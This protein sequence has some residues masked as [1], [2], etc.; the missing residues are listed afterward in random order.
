MSNKSTGKES[1]IKSPFRGLERWIKVLV[2]LYSIIGIALFY[3]Q[4]YFLFHPTVLPRGH[5]YHF[6]FPFAEMDL[7]FNNTDTV[8]MVKFFPTDSTR[9]G[10]VLYFHG[11]KGNINRYAKF[12]GNFTKHGYE[13]WM[14]DYPGF[15]KSIGQR[16]E[17][18][19]YQQAVQLYKLALTKYHQDSIVI[20][21]KSF[22]TGIASY[23]AAVSDAKQLILETPYYSIPALY[24]CYAPIYPSQRMAKYKIPSN[25]YLMEV[26]YPVTIFHGTNDGVIPYRC[27]AKLK[28][29]LKPTDQFITIDGGTHH[30]LNDFPLFQQKLD[31]LLE[32][33]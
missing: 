22:G 7:P 21:G 24:S 9:K 11:N 5:R 19:L 4:E 29:V 28:T 33:R 16:T 15:G 18:I 1:E 3:L 27:A 26:K 10:V 6:D 32:L 20:Y 8:N 2:L 12:A 14:E 25:E 13:V 23:L 17:K 31:S 30:N